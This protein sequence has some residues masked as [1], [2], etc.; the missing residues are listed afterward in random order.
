MLEF[1]K[2]CNVQLTLSSWLLQLHEKR[3]PHRSFMSTT[4]SSKGNV[5]AVKENGILNGNETPKCQKIGELKLSGPFLFPP[6]G[7]IGAKS[8]PPA[9]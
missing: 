1:D 7:D 8:S 2:C 3:S 9:N 6:E 4:A 5:F